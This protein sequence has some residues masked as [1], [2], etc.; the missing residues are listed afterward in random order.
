MK[1]PIPTPVKIPV[2]SPVLTVPPVLVEPPDNLVAPRTPVSGV[3]PEEVI[4]SN[5]AA[6]VTGLDGITNVVATLPESAKTTPSD[7]VHPANRIP[8][9]TV[10]VMEIVAPGTEF[11]KSETPPTIEIAYRVGVTVGVGVTVAVGSGVGDG[12][13][14]G[15]GDGVATTIFTQWAYKIRGAFTATDC[16]TA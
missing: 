10:A 13:G 15:D 7:T 9:G 1:T 5:L 3:T 12:D 6:I 14:D 11:G 4:F 8:L 2:L 16:P